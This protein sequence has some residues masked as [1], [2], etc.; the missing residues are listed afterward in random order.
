[1]SEITFVALPVAEK[2][3]LAVAMRPTHTIRDLSEKLGIGTKQAFNW[4]RHLRVDLRVRRKTQT[5]EERCSCS[6]PISDTRFDAYCKR[7]RTCFRCGKA[8]AR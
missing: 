1:M 8:V 2:K 5:S 6:Q 3:K 7:T 4:T